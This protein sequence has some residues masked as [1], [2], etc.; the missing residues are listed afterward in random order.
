ML[1]LR[2]LSLLGGTAAVAG[3]SSDLDCRLNG[4]CTA[5]ACVCTAA[6]RGANCST[7]ALQPTAAMGDLRQPNVSTWG[8]G[9][10]HVGGQWHGYFAEMEEGCG[11]TSWQSN[12][13]IAHA[14]APSPNGP[15]QRV[16]QTSGVWSH[17]PATAVAP[18]GTLLLFHIGSGSGGKAR[19]SS[20]E[21]SQQCRGGS[22]PCGTH[23]SH[24]CNTTSRISRPEQQHLPT[25]AATINFFTAKD[26]AGPWSPFSATVSGGKSIGG[27]NPAPWVHPNGSIFIVFNS[28]NM[29]MVR[30]EHWK[31]PYEIVTH[32]AC[33]SGEDPFL[34]ETSPPARAPLTLT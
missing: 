4:V 14:V 6:W 13:L 8:M 5:G 26:P 32:D 1:L 15:W 3:C 25:A 22:S 20:R 28:D 31:G 18:D 30:A 29:V 12:S 23:P 17:N 2:L 21:S 27:N 24:H 7:L 11:L 16:G 19:T 33:G 10:V 34:C 9:S